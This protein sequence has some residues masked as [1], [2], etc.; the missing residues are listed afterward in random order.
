MGR[1][2]AHLPVVAGGQ[3]SAAA[4]GKSK[5][6][7]VKLVSLEGCS[8]LTTQGLEAVVVSFKELESLRV[9]SCNNIK[10][11]EVSPALSNLFAT[12]KNLKWTPDNRSLVL[13]SLSES[14]M[15][16]R[17]GRFFKKLQILN[18]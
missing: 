2:E 18:T 7:R 1:R 15:G 6:R 3:G 5:S 14:G 12:L 9:I 17:G 16:K 4:A 8:R 10:E 11:D 13:T